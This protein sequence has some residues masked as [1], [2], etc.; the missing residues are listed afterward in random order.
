MYNV[1]AF[2][3]KSGAGKD[4]ILNAVCEKYPNLNKKVSTT[5]RPPRDYEK[6]GVDYYFITGE[7]FTNKVLN[8]EMAE[9]TD[10]REWFYGTEYRALKE[11]GLN[12]GVFN[13]DGVRALSEDSKINLLVI[14]VTVSDKTRIIRALNR[15][16]N[17]DIEE[18]FRRYH[19]DELDFSELNFDYK[20]VSNEDK[21]IDEVVEEVHEIIIGHFGQR[22]FM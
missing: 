11:K 5:T 12:V 6:D 2:M 8:F 10:F 22:K 7:E 3:G 4:T 14:Y 16:V 17:P 15:E 1:I 20:L 18:I 9:A 21:S 19:T 13:P